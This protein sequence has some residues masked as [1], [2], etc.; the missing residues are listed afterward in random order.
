VCCARNEWNGNASL[1][2]D[3]PEVMSIIGKEKQRQKAGLE[4]IASEVRKLM[5]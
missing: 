1:A 2:A 4:L 3:D 5:K